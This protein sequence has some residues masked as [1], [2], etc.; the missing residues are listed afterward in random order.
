MRRVALTMAGGV[1]SVVWV[2]KT[3]EPL[4]M[5]QSPVRAVPT[6]HSIMQQM[7]QNIF[8]WEMLQAH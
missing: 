5:A 4:I 3:S 6:A 1:I 8:Q 7:E 2:L